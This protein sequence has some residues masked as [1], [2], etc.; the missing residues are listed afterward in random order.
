MPCRNI[1]EKYFTFP[2]CSK[3]DENYVV[4]L[5]GVFNYYTSKYLNQMREKYNIHYIMVL[6]DPLTGFSSAFMKEEL[7]N[8]KYDFLYSF[9]AE[10]AKN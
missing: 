8:T 10:D 3:D 7:F 5:N 9:D 4:L 1:W 6:I 2:K